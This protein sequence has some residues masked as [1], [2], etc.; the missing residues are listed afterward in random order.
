MWVKNCHLA[1]PMHSCRGNRCGA[2]VTT[3]PQVLE[4]H[5]FDLTNL[6]NAV[7]PIQPVTS[8][9][10]DELQSLKICFLTSLTILYNEMIRDKGNTFTTV[11]KK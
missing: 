3:L 5:N 2:T 1:Y 7:K 6:I 11:S 9:H 8:L 10:S 4:S